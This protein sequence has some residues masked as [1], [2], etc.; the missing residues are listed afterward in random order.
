VNQ[1]RPYG[2]ATAEASE[3][4]EAELPEDSEVLDCREVRRVARHFHSP[5]SPPL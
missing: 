5:A 1:A 3:G 2:Q 4:A